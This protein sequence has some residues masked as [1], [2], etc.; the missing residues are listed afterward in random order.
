MSRVRYRLSPFIGLTA[1]ALGLAGAAAPGLAEERPRQGPVD[2]EHAFGQTVGADVEEPGAVVPH[3]VLPSAF[4]RRGGTF[5]S[6][7]PSLEIKF[8]VVENFAAAV[9]IRGLGSSVRN[10][11]GMTDVSGAWMTGIGTSGRFR[12]M[13]RDKGPFGMTLQIGAATDQRNIGTG[14]AGRA[15][16]LETRLAFDFEPVFDR[17]LM[18]GNVFFVTARNYSP[19]MPAFEATS[20][21]GLSGAVTTRVAS[22][23]WLGGEIQYTRAYGG[24][25][26]GRYQGDAVHVGPTL[27][28]TLD[29]A[30]LTVSYGIQVA[31]TEVGG[32]PGLNLREFE[33]HRLLVV[34]GR[35]F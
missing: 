20:T 30:W 25:T 26:L 10:V 5:F 6:T 15:D 11:P 12:L 18:A 27:Y 2:T 17:V 8:G 29:K 19:G 7:T 9:A 33:R 3:L 14:L 13:E 28:A 21:L 35:A 31:G 16:Q 1:L 23:L 22:N 24:S 34:L 32:T 4:G